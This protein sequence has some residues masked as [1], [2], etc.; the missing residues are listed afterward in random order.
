MGI[1]GCGLIEGYREGV[2]SDRGYGEGV[3][4]DGGLQVGGLW[5]RG[6]MN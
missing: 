6:M 4:S 5:R 3:W 1:R 2:W